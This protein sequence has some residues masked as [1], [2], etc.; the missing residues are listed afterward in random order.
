MVDATNDLTAGQD[1][2][3]LSALPY[4]TERVPSAQG[5]PA[6]N[7][8]GWENMANPRFGDTVADLFYAGPDIDDRVAVESL[9]GD[10][11]FRPSMSVPAP[12][13]TAP[14]TA[15]RLCGSRSLSAS[16]GAG[17]WRCGYWLTA[18][19]HRSC[20]APFFSDH[21]TKEEPQ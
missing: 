9:I 8:V 20:S 13:P 18:S 12:T 4:L 2:Q 21:I 16:T 17:D 1:S 14:S 10:V 5:F 6:F 19:K 7:S 15:W 3:S 11:G